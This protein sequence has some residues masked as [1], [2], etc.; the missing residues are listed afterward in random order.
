MTYGDCRLDDETRGFLEK[1]IDK[2]FKGNVLPHVEWLE[3]EHPIS[4]MHDLAL[5]YFVGTLTTLMTALTAIS[6]QTDKE[7]KEDQ[8]AIRTMVRRRLPEILE[9]IG[10]ELNR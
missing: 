3:V 8:K 5:G 1:N 4:S 6:K 10:I 9:K 2:F 7:F